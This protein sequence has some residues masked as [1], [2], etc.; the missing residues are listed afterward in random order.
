[1]ITPQIY[2]T[3]VTAAKNAARYDINLNG[4]SRDPIVPMLKTNSHRI[5]S[6]LALTTLTLA[7]ASFASGATYYVDSTLGND[8]NSGTIQSAPWQT[9]TKVDAT[10]FQPGDQILF[11]CG[12][13]WTGVLSP[14]GSGTSAS[15][16]VINSY[17]SGAQP[18]I[19]GNGVT[20]GAVSL[21][22]QSYWEI[23]NLEVTN[24]ASAAGIPASTM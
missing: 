20:G 12:D 17:G 19:Q 18:L 24:S 4:T 9:L 5:P 23:N 11:L 10:T 6:W 7:A 13:V 3:T 8:S 21:A 2:P 1:M 16:I 14:K 22:N 15:P